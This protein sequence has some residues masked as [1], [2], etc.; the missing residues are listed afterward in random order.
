MQSKNPQKPRGKNKHKK[1]NLNI[2]KTQ[3]NVGGDTKE[4]KNNRFPCNNVMEDHPT[5]QCPKM[6]EIHQ[7]FS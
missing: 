7:Y 6:D 1:K 3:N 5:H 2:L 4:K